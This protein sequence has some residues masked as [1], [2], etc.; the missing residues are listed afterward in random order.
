MGIYRHAALYLFKVV[1]KNPTQNARLHERLVNIIG[2]LFRRE[3]VRDY[4]GA[5]LALFHP[6]KPSTARM[7]QMMRS[8][9][10]HEFCP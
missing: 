7:I 10:N 4:F 2:H 8:M 9:E 1:N 6:D 3:D 5:R